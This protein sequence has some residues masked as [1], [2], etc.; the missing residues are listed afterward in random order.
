[1][2]EEL[3]DCDFLLFM[4]ADAFFYSHELRIED[5]LLPL[6]EDK[7]ILMSADYVHEGD[8]HQPDKPNTGVILVRNSEKTAEF[9]RVW[10]ATSEQ[11]GMEHFRFNP[12]YEQETCYQTVWQKYAEEVKLLKDYYRMNSVRGMYIRHLMGTPE[13]YRFWCQEKFLND[14]NDG[15]ER[16]QTAADA[17]ESSSL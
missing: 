9:L 17:S 6:L 3:H 13:E 5:E 4:D 7:Q 12:F 11:P 10:D 16:Q 8:R 1:M 14:R 2:R 15:G